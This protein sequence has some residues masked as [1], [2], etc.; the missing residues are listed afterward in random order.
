MWSWLRVSEVA[1]D[2]TAG[3]AVSEGLT[4]LQDLF[5]TWLTHMLLAAG[6]T[7]VS[8]GPLATRDP[9]SRTSDPEGE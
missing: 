7:A 5:L 9:P 3:A 2:M 8:H 6:F 4:G 1:G